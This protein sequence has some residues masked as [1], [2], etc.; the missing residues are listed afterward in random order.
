MFPSKSIQLWLGEKYMYVANLS[1]T[2]L[3]RTII[4]NER[5]KERVRM[6]K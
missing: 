5:E 2:R 1:T 6:Y 4:K 3:S